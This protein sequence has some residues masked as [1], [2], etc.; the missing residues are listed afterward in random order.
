MINKLFLLLLPFFI[1]SIFATN[2]F[3]QKENFAKLYNIKSSE[4][5][6][7]EDIK[8]LIYYAKMNQAAFKSDEVIHSLYPDALIFE[9]PINKVKVFIKFDDNKQHQDVIIRGSDNFKN[10]IENIKIFKK[11]DKWAR[12]VKTHIGFHNMAREIY[13]LI[14]DQLKTNYSTTVSGHSL[15]GSTAVLVGLYLEHFK[16]PKVNVLSFGQ[17]R[18][19]NKKGAQ[20]LNNFSLK[21]VAHEDDIVTKLA[22]KFV[23][24]RHFGSLFTLSGYKKATENFV[25]DSTDSPAVTKTWEQL[26]TGEIE[27][28]T[29]IKSHN[30]INYLKR[31]HNLLPQ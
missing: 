30:I 9:G 21:R 1:S 27:V 13:S 23:G 10:W 15:G 16:F 31:L 18:V 5:T 11:K 2:S 12:G 25:E 6:D 4:T 19:T 20:I 22:P 14:K 7:E 28:Q 26:E 24:Y 29:N 8:N 3:V 17:P